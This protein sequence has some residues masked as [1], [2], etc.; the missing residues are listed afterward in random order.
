MDATLADRARAKERGFVPP[1]VNGDFYR[2]AD[3]LDPT[4]RAVVKRVRDF[5]EKYEFFL[6]PVNQV[7]PFDV[8]QHHPTEINGVKMDN[9][10]SWMKS[11]CYITAAGNPAASVPC[12]GRGSP[13]IAPGRSGRS[14]NSFRNSGRSSSSTHGTV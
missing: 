12:A 5:M 9:Y 3:L 14:Q 13:S 2:I 1:P 11:A 10:L 8:T 7:L 6:L 4:E